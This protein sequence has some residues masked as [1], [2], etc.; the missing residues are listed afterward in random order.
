M[1]VEQMIHM[2]SLWLSS[3]LLCIQCIVLQTSY[4]YQVLIRFTIL[5]GPSQVPSQLSFTT[6][7][8][9]I[10]IYTHVSFNVNVP[11]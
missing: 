9:I 3:K 5:N 4:N 2:R 8:K 11:T 6:S 1:L 10:F 7:H